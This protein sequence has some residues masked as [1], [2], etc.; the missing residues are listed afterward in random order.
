MSGTS[1]ITNKLL[2]SSVNNSCFL[3]DNPNETNSWVTGLN[4]AYTNISHR[5]KLNIEAHKYVK[6]LTWSNVINQI[7]DKIIKIL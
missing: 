1:V 4:F 3:I 5:G 6:N 7:E 2:S